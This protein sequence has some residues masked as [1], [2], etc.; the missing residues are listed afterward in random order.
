MTAR[1]QHNAARVCSTP[2]TRSRA[3]S[4]ERLYQ[5]SERVPCLFQT[6]EED[7]E[8]PHPPSDLNAIGE[9]I[10]MLMNPRAFYEARVSSR[11]TS[12]CT[13][14]VWRALT[15]CSFHCFHVFRKRQEGHSADRDVP[16]EAS[17]MPFYQV[18]SLCDVAQMLCRELDLPRICW[19]YGHMFSHA[20]WRLRFDP[21]QTS[22]S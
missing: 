4:Q 22:S 13:A 8:I 19:G 15:L 3:R 17:S 2:A 5:L 1:L 7:T 6:D 14:G 20:V 21:T 9:H 12:G 18:Y 11:P 10:A 16:L